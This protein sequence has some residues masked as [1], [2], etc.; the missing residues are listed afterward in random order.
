MASE[1]RK[2]PGKCDLQRHLESMVCKN[3]GPA[4]LSRA[5]KGGEWFLRCTGTG[6]HRCRAAACTSQ[7]P[8][9][10]H[11]PFLSALR[12]RLY[13][14]ASGGIEG[15]QISLRNMFVTRHYPRQA[16]LCATSG[17]SAKLHEKTEGGAIDSTLGT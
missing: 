13:A 15:D 14:R 9:Q 7:F 2:D 4:I 12:V 1:P 6:L 10:F 3:R 5:G 16:V 8:S 11:K 17:E